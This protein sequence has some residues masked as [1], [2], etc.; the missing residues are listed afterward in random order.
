MVYG[1]S[2][3][4]CCVAIVVPHAD[5]VKKWAQEHG[6]D[7]QDLNEVIKDPIFKKLI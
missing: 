5:K 1:D 4:S 6:K 2:L 7:G 3:R